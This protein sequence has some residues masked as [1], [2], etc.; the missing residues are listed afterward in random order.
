MKITTAIVP[1]AGLGTRLLPVSQA[2]PKELLPLGRKPALHLIA[3]ELGRA[4]IERVILVSSNAKQQI[5]NYFQPNPILEKSLLDSGKYELL[6][7]LWSQSEFA[8]V[9]FE[10]VIQQEQRGLGHA[11]LCAAERVQDQPVVVALGDCVMGIGGKSNILQDLVGVYESNSANVVIGFEEV[12]ED[13]VNRFGIAD[14]KAP[15][16]NGVFELADVVEKPDLANAPSRYAIAARYVFGPMIFE[17]LRETTPGKNNEIQLTDAI[18]T[19][20]KES[21][22]AFGVLL[23]E[24][25]F[26]MGNIHSY[27]DAFTRF[28]LAD[29]TLRGD[30]LNAIQNDKNG[31]TWKL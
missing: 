24:P 9:E 27:V 28:A 15:P 30:V 4:G 1:V 22:S 6:E 19:V 16:E 8:N 14:P 31:E 13:R 10:V 21:G 17:S 3:E 23:Q 29:P 11:V 20:I 5:A 26:D 18:R 7:Q 12:S 2:V 25:R